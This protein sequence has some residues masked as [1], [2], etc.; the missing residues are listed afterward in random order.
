MSLQHSNIAQVLDLGVA[1]GRYFLALELVDGWDLERILQRAYAAGIVWP[2]ALSLYV[3]GVRLPR[4][5]LRARQGARRQAAGHRPPRHQPEQRAD[6]RPGR[7]QADRL[8]HRQGAAQAR[9]DRGRRHQG[10]GRVHVARAGAGRPA[11]DK[12][13]DIFSV[14]S[15]LYRMVTEKLPFEASDDME[16]LLRVQKAEFT[17][18]EQVKPTVGP[19]VSTIIMRAMR[20]APSERYQTADEMLAD[21]ER[22]LRNEF[23]SA[24]QTELKLWLEQLGAPRRRADASAS[25][26]STRAA[27]SRT[28]WGPTCRRG[29]RSSSTTSTR[30]SAPTELA[31]LMRSDAAASGPPRRRGR[32]ADRRRRCRGRAAPAAALRVL[33]GRHLRA[34]RGDRHPLREELGGAE[35]RRRRRW[36]CGGDAS[37][38][39][40]ATAIAGARAHD[41]GAA[42]A[43]ADGR[44]PHRRPRRPRRRPVA[45]AGGRRRRR[46]PTPTPEATPPAIRSRRRAPDARP[47][48]ADNHPAAGQ[49]GN[50]RRPT[51][52][53]T[54]TTTSPTRRRCCATRSPTPRTR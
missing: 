44:R 4:A 11:I 39:A 17:P 38:K 25:G 1:G 3:V 2:A 32:W 35:G 12:R 20:L 28:R 19:A 36:G 50:R 45:D 23:H 51:A 41:A 42:R 34:R 47:E 26:A 48:I 16:S 53:K 33:A 24:G 21:V 31:S 14:G 10:Q 40:A 27:S 22:V 43:G 7:D 46:T 30:R 15:M 5:G 9:A 18:P 6:Q 54:E 49:A 52:S 29:R 13:S 8:R 37:D